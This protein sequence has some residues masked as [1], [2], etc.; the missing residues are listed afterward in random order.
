MDNITLFEKI[1]SK[2]IFQIINSYIKDENLFYKLIFYNK[3]L[4][5]KW[6]LKLKEKYFEEHLK[7]EK[8]LFVDFSSEDGL[9]NNYEED[10]LFYNLDES[11]FK[12][13]V[14]NYFEKY[15][16]KNKKESNKY[17]I[18]FFSPFFEVLSKE[19]YFENIF[20]IV[21][22]L[23]DFNKYKD[24]YK[25][26]FDKLNTSNSRYPSLLFYY[27]SI[28]ELYN[29]NYLNINFNI[30]KNISFKTNEIE[31][32][33]EKY[34]SNKY[35][36][37]D[38]L[39]F[40]EIQNNLVYL[41]IELKQPQK[42][43]DNWNDLLN[44]FNS[45]NY[46]KLSFF[47]F[48][49]TFELQLNQLKKLSLIK[50]KNITFKDNIFLNLEK[51]TLKYN[52]ILKP[53]QSLMQCPNLEKCTFANDK[54]VL[55]NYNLIIDFNSLKSLKYYKGDIIY[56][57]YLGKS[58]EKV[59]LFS[60]YVNNHG[61]LYNYENYYDYIYNNDNRNKLDKKDKITFQK[62]IT[63][64]KLKEIIFFNN[65]NDE[66]IQEIKGVNTSV[67]KLTIKGYFKELYNLQNKFPNLTELN[68]KPYNK[69][70]KIDQE[71]DIKENPKCKINKFKLFTPS[72]FFI[73]SYAKLESIEFE[74]QEGYLSGLDN[75]PLLNSN[76]NITFNSLILFHFFSK[77]LNIGT[78]LF[79]NLANNINKMPN[80]KDLEINSY[81]R[82]K[83]FNKDFLNEFI[84]N[85]LSLEFIKKVNI[86]LKSVYESRVVLKEY[87]RNEL[88]QMY[89][90]IN[91]NK[92]HEIKIHINY[93]K[94]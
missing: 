83:L 90:T 34:I 53:K 66:M 70:N 62:L 51:L 60:N 8:Y 31:K 36:P 9:K 74:I 72:K 43:N 91:I 92:L 3:S 61:E 49:S 42:I 93:Y 10:S 63:M 87:S 75:F 22:N 18:S 48:D 12:Q 4:Q 67:E 86:E 47:N 38:I 82:E 88:K 71:I 57:F 84:K 77:N 15:E 76:C 45:L 52:N 80:L 68:I 55:C 7:W 37:L 73:Q 17:L 56:F 25:N 54:T 6:N 79:S 29:I 46:L 11:F 24:F 94:K 39:T 78:Y 23:K 16:K 13:I 89:P 50:C 69:I 40:N 30:I 20:T 1:N 14:I 58:L 35:L 28:D 59:D 2:Y 64:K 5:Q 27:N 19:K 44:K 21:V 41:R 26:N 81:Y 32:L 65:I 85:I 33:K